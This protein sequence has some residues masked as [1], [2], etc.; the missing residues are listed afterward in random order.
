M[1]W[2]AELAVI[3]GPSGGNDDFDITFGPGFLLRGGLVF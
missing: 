2:L 3:A 1:A